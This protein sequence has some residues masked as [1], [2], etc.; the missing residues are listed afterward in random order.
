MLGANYHAALL[1]SSAAERAAHAQQRAV[2]L[3]SPP[4]AQPAMPAAPAERQLQSPAS[5]AE[6]HQAVQAEEEPS[7]L[8]E[9]AGLDKRLDETQRRHVRAQEEQR[10]PVEDRDLHRRDH[11]ADDVRE[12]HG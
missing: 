9:L 7:V 10:L 2:L 1:N 12:E 5:A 4:P 11:R 8:Q 6:L 3:G